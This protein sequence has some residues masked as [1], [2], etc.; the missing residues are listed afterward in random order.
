MSSEERPAI[1]GDELAAALYAEQG[2]FVASSFMPRKIGDID[3]D[4]SHHP[5]KR[6]SA[7][8]RVVGDATEKEWIS[9]WNM[10]HELAPDITG[11]E[12]VRSPWELYFYRV[13]ACD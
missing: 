11:D 3:I 4:N 12:Y 5:T 8:M 10:A 6:V 1:T 13:E 2:Y 9:Q 7:T